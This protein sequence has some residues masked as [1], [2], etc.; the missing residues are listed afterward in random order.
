MSG[1]VQAALLLPVALGLFMLLVQWSLVVWAESVALAAAEHG[2]A[3]C[4]LSGGGTEA[5]RSAALRAADGAALTEVEVLVTRNADSSQVT[6]S[7][8]A[9]AL[10]WRG[11]VTKTV[12]MPNERLTQS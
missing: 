11:E 8:R 2:A 6:V 9:T 10:L 7:G 3:A 4:A 1:S 12:S 5:G